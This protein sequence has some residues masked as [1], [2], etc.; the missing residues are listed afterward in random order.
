MLTLEYAKDPVYNDESGNSI[1]LTVKWEEFAEE[2]PFS[3]NTWDTEP[4]G[5]EL[6]AKAKAGEYGEVKPFIIPPPVPPSAEGN[7]QTAIKKL[8]ATDW[9]A[10][11]DIANPEYSNPYLTNQDAFLAYR[12]QVREYAVNPVAGF[13]DWPTEPTAIWANV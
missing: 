12:S 1:C 7:K 9:A 2:M 6:Y 5:L 8:Q 11:V 4:W 3:A 13:I 10:T